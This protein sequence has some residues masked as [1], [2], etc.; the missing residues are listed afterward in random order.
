MRSFETTHLHYR[1]LFDI[2]EIPASNNAWGNLITEIRRWINAKTSKEDKVYGTWFYRGNLGKPKLFRPSL[3]ITAASNIGN[4]EENSPEY[5][6]AKLEEADNE[7]HQ[8]RRWTTDI[9]VSTIEHGKYRFSLIVSC[10]ILPGFIG[11]EPPIP[12]P[13]TPKIV[14]NF[15]TS[16]SWTAC[17]GEERL[18]FEP[19]HLLVGNVPDFIE[20]LE[21][22]SR[23][24]PIVYVSR[25][26]NT[27]E[28]LVD[29]QKLAKLLAGNAV[30]Y[31]A[32][33]SM[34][35]K[36]TEH[37]FPQDFR[38]WNGMIRVYQPKVDFSSDYDSGRH[39]YFKASDVECHTPE[40]VINML[41]RGISR[42]PIQWKKSEITTLSDIVSKHTAHKIKELSKSD[43]NISQKE[44][45]EELEKIY[46]E[47]YKLRECND[48]LEYQVL[49]LEEKLDE[50][51]KELTRI[52]YEKLKLEESLNIKKNSL[53]TLESKIGIIDNLCELPKNLIEVI[54]LIEKIHSDRITFTE[55]A[56]KSAKEA[57][58]VSNHMAW[59]CLWS[60][61][62]VL[63]DL[64]F[65]STE[66]QIDIE[67]AFKE[68]TGF[69][70]AMTEGRQTRRDPK[71][72]KQREIEYQG[73]RLNIE[74]HVKCGS[75]K[76][77]LLRVYFS[78]H[79]E[80]KKIIVG[81]CGNHLE[82]YS[83]Q[84]RK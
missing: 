70:L 59:Q 80:S 47:N 57:T 53:S 52:D 12:V 31:L 56:K 17:A 74:P 84:F 55:D 2:S 38:C 51:G 13:T 72:L 34:L 61:A 14:I 7:Y 22:P 29:V 54:E 15:L 62:T 63:H 19:S 37:F 6:A 16:Q 82:N 48:K 43:Q 28:P 21:S 76:P 5:W 81:H 36:E 50:K 65:E 83:S 30:V 64:F 66:E 24:C 26:Y 40:G 18:S 68:R 67:R 9:G 1:T 44:W 49:E 69:E 41:V 27:N 39:R 25:D 11:E 8:I 58:W 32:E 4:G 75:R 71:L 3:K 79:S 45:V 35:D 10:S 42:R 46:E 78:P 77:K 73:L 60:I 20:K 23:L 33:S